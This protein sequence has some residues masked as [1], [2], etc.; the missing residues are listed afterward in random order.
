MADDSLK[1]AD[2]YLAQGDYVRA[3]DELQRAGPADPA[4]THRIHTALDRMKLMAAREF[5]V[6]RW[7][8]AEGIA[9][10]VQEH[11]QFLSAE[12]QRE[13]RDLVS[14]I[15]RCRDRGKQVHGLI[16]AAA[17]LAAS[18]QYLQSREVALRAMGTCTDPHL[19]ARLRRLLRTLPHPLGQLVYGFDSG[20][21]VEQFVRTQAGASVQT[22]FEENHLLSGGYAR[23]VLPRKGA[24]VVLMDP[25]PDW[26]DFKELS[27]CVRLLSKT[28][29]SMLIRAGDL[30]NSWVHEL[31]LVH[32]NWDQIRILLDRFVK[33]GEPAWDNVTSFSIVSQADEPLE[34][35]LDEIR[36][37]SRGLPPGPAAPRA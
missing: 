35:G 20:L 25:P 27:C 30:R 4:I 16:Q 33:Q 3:L 11:E 5:A 18:N 12:E 26:S 10:A 23:I 36:L 13:C 21:E 24:A 19:M 28:R 22:V 7:S 2:R 29:S 17:A 1:Q 37:K 15:G 31:K 32:R 34:I 14:E 8:V 6:G 9:D